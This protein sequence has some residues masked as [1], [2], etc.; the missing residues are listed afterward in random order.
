MIADLRAGQPVGRAREFPPPEEAGSHTVSP[1]VPTLT[2]GTVAAGRFWLLPFL[3]GTHDESAAGAAN[4]GSDDNRGGCGRAIHRRQWIQD[5]IINE[6]RGIRQYRRPKAPNY[7]QVERFKGAVDPSSDE[8]SRYC[9][10]DQRDQRQSPNFRREEGGEHRESG[11]ENGK[12]RDA[13]QELAEGELIPSHF[14]CRR[15][16]A[17]GLS[18]CSSLADT[19]RH[20]RFNRRAGAARTDCDRWNVPDLS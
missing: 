4:Q 2:Q 16:T 14:T 17:S 20:D 5:E 15:S 6:P 12:E 8:C 11:A 3:D 9:C 18:W 10:H 19:T 1:A 7:G 13:Y